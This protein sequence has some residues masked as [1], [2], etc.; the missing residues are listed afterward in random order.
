MIRSARIAEAEVLERQ[1]TVLS[2]KQVAFASQMRVYSSNKDQAYLDAELQYN[3][4]QALIDELTTKADDLVSNTTAIAALAQKALRTRQQ[5]LQ[6]HAEKQVEQERQGLAARRAERLK[7]EQVTLT[8]VPDTL[9]SIENTPTPTTEGEAE[10]PT[11]A[12]E[13]LSNGGTREADNDVKAALS[14][15]QQIWRGER[16]RLVNAIRMDTQKAVLQIAHAKNWHLVPPGT[17]DAQD[18]TNFVKQLLKA[19]WKQPNP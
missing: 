4:L 14:L 6:Q 15:Q 7:R 9:P 19:E 17:P 13:A 8:S 12:S 5:E 10:K 3:H 16:A 1:I 11:H 2:F 18:I